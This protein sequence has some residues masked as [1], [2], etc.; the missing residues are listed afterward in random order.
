LAISCR[1]A[2]VPIASMETNTPTA[3]ATPMMIV[4]TGAVRCLTPDRFMSN[5]LKNCRVKFMRPR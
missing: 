4:R 5:M 1:R 2:P 3:Q